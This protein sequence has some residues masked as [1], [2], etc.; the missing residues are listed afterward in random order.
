MIEILQN[1]GLVFGYSPSVSNL[2]INYTSSAVV[3]SFF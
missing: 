1:L 3:F 2:N